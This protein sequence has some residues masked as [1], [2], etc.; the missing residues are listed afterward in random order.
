[1]K[2]D[3]MQTAILGGGC[4]WCLEAVYQRLR[5]VQ[6]VVSGY[7]GGHLPQPDY[8]SVCSAKSGHAEVVQIEFDPAVIRYQDLLDVFFEIHD[9][10]TLNRQGNDVGPQYRS[11]IFALTGDQFT[12]AQSAIASRNGKG[13]FSQPL[14]TELIDLS[15]PARPITTETTFFPAEPEHQ[16]YF[17]RHPTVGYCVFVVAAKVAKAEGRFKA[18]IAQ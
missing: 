16:N 13:L 8:E 5:G 17:N 7:M 10:T 1:M 18:L 15:D 9:P 12:A 14:V 2:G 6:R 4:F 11:I 3:L